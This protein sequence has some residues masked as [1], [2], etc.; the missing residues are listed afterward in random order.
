MILRYS[1]ET[2]RRNTMKILCS[3]YTAEDETE[4]LQDCANDEAFDKAMGYY[5]QGY[6]ISEAVSTACSEV[7]NGYADYYT[8]DDPMYWISPDPDAVYKL[9][10]DRINEM[11][12]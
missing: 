3:T 12:K 10:Q 6:D 9:V 11:E 7:D 1:I 2:D 5:R 4:Y 8:E